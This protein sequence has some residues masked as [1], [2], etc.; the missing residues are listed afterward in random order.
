MQISCMIWV[1]NGYEGNSFDLFIAHW[2][3]VLH[4]NVR[5]TA[6]EWIKYS[7]MSCDVVRR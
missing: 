2:I 7:F 1:E 5:E 6:P 4:L 3:C